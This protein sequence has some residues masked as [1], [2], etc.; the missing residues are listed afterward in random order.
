MP[1]WILGDAPV[2]LRG[3]GVGLLTAFVYGS[4]K[5]WSSGGVM[6]P[7]EVV[8]VGNGETAPGKAGNRRWAGGGLAEP[9]CPWV[10][11]F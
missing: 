9:A 7:I 10:S 11:S 5:C 4:G 6:G 8:D 1:R 2:K 3:G